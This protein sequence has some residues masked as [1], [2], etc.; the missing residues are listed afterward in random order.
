MTWTHGTQY[1]YRQQGC[2]CLLCRTHMSEVRARGREY[3]R[4]YRVKHREERRAYN[5]EW[6]QRYRKA[7]R[8]AGTTPA[9]G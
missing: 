3:M 4:Q 2:R 1:G 9:G 8:S 6:M 5:R 7:A